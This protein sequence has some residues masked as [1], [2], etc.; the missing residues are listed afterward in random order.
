MPKPRAYSYARVSSRLQL[1]G[2]GLERQLA[3]ARKWCVEND[4]ELDEDF[5]LVDPGRSAFKGDHLRDGV[6]GQLLEMFQ[7]HRIP[8]GS[9]LLIEAV[10]RLSRQEPLDALQDV[11]LA[12]AKAGAVIV[13][14]ED[15]QRYSRETLN[16]DPLALVKLALRIQA[17]H[18]YSRRLSRRVGE[19]WS[20][21]RA[22]YRSGDTLA[23]GGKGGRKP[24]WVSLSADEKRWELNEHADTVR[25]IVDLLQMNGA[26][27]AAQQLNALGICT[28]TG[29]RWSKNSVL[30]IAHDPAICGA[31]VLGR[32]AH[33]DAHAAMRRWEVSPRLGPPPEVPPKVETVSGYWPPAVTEEVFD[34]LQRSLKQRWYE[35]ASKGQRREVSSFLRGLACCQHGSPMSVQLSMRNPNGSDY[36]YLR[37]SRRRSGPGCQCS[38]RGW[39]VD[40]LQAHVC[41]RLGRA[42]I[43]IGLQR[44][45]DDRRQRLQ[46][47]EQRTQEAQGL[48]R[49]AELRLNRARQAMDAA[50][51]EGAS[52]S[53]LERLNEAVDARADELQQIQ[54]GATEAADNLTQAQASPDLQDS[55]SRRPALELMWAV[56]QRNETPD[57]QRGLHKLLR[58]LRLALVLDDSDPAALRVGMGCDGEVWGWQ[59]FIGAAEPARLFVEGVVL[60][61]IRDHTPSS[62]DSSGLRI[63]PGAS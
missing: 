44:P 35:P 13:D 38:G 57:Q 15:G 30:R 24:Y 36:A 8:S 58:S 45:D 28:S 60:G 19:H 46:Q 16:A 3:M 5:E 61:P 55:L 10:D 1:K 22:R 48:I 62:P 7:A 9:V 59:P 21:A 47:L 4:H 49:S 32:R 25:R 39:R 54:Q 40:Q 17:A 29:A 56:A 11:F 23:R 41:F 34:R 31:L 37:C 14:L 50:L 18:D 33:A 63:D 43:G 52:V 51:D 53:L 27:Q 42:A 12:L 20:Q 6:L 26:T 2:G